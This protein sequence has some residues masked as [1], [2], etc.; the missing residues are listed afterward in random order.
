MSLQG[1]I[2]A[3]L[4]GT[5]SLGSYVPVLA[6][7][8]THCWKLLHYDAVLHFHG[9]HEQLPSQSG[10]KVCDLH[11]TNA[12]DHNA[13]A[14]VAALGQLRFMSLSAGVGH[15]NDNAGGD[16]PTHRPLKIALHHF[17]AMN[18][19]YKRYSCCLLERFTSYLVELETPCVTAAVAHPPPNYALFLWVKAACNGTSARLA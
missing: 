2:A 16:H 19:L 6:L 15:H 17:T 14:Y 4:N 12:H 7:P 10:L 8:S 1:R 5:P 13:K 11:A 3:Q 9:D 18:L